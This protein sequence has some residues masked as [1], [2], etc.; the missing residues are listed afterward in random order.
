MTTIW[1]YFPAKDAY[2][3]DNC[4]A[5]ARQLFDR[6]AAMKGASDIIREK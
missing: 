6:Q 5:T 4:M 1:T 2:L 3:F